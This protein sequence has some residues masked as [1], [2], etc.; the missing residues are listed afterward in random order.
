MIQSNLP[1]VTE[2]CD[3][4]VSWSQLISNLDSSSNIQTWWCSNKEAFF[5][6][7]PKN[8]NMHKREAN[9]YI[10]KIFLMFM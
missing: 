9:N 4:G 3:N 1:S 6:Q 2:T 8:L 7:K 5:S 10:K